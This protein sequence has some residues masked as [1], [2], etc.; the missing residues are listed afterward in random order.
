MWI[1]KQPE[2][3]HKTKSFNLI[4]DGFE[5]DLACKKRRDGMQT[6]Y[7]IM[8]DHWLLLTDFRRKPGQ[9]PRRRQSTDAGGNGSR[10]GLYSLAWFVINEVIYYIP[11]FQFWVWLIVFLNLSVC[12]KPGIIL[13]AHGRF[14]RH[15]QCWPTCQ[16]I[17]IFH[18][19]IVFYDQI[20]C[21]MNSG[22]THY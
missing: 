15:C 9:S 13:Y 21:L 19:L 20:N 18:L 17:T 10:P 14:K 1:V 8:K 7:G 2:R 11:K 4:N 5:I 22:D 3:F 6:A 12:S 16:L